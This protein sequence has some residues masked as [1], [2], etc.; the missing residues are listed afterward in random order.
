MTAR[1]NV[2]LRQIIPLW[3]SEIG[4]PLDSSD[5]SQQHFLGDF[6]MLDTSFPSTNSPE[7]Y[8]VGQQ[9]SATWKN[10]SVAEN[11]VED[12]TI[13]YLDLIYPSRKSAFIEMP[14]LFFPFDVSRLCRSY[15]GKQHDNPTSSSKQQHRSHQTTQTS[16]TSLLLELESDL[17]N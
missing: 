7:G 1:I 11:S 14:P 2:S 6:Q 3:P 5:F 8:T 16:N 9:G 15:L 13:R 4:V 10:S 17:S 12:S